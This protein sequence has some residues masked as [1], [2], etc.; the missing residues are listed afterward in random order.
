MEGYYSQEIINETIEYVKSFHYIDD[1][2]YAC[3]Y[4]FFHKESESRKKME[5]KLLRKGINREILEQAFN[6]SYDEGEQGE[7]ELQQAK[8]LLNKKKYDADSM[9]WIEKQ[10]VYAFLAGKGICSSTIRKAMCLQKDSL[11]EM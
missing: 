10:K 7:I 1:Y 3:R 11:E 4:I 9:D 6:D 5:E 8:K 2:D